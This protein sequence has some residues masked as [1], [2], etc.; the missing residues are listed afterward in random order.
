MGK[1][2]R[3]PILSPPNLNIELEHDVGNWG[4]MPKDM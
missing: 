3:I 2:P 4:D 1:S